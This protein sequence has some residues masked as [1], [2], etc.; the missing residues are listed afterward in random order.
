MV[1][2]LEI[3]DDIWYTF[4]TWL[5]TIIFEEINRYFSSNN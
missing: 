2:K 5:N 3:W 4:E 1:I